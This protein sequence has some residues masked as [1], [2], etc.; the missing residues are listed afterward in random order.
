MVCG[1]NPSGPANDTLLV[2]K[3]ATERGRLLATVVNYACHPTTLAWENT[4]VSPDYIGALRESVEQHARAPCLFLQGAS[5][6][7]GPRHGYVGDTAVADANGRELAFAALAALEALPPPGTH[8][9]YSGPVESGATLGIWRHEPTSS[10]AAGHT[11]WQTVQVEVPLA[12]RKELSSKAATQAELSR[13]QDELQRRQAALDRDEAAKAHAHVER[14]TRQLWKLS[15]LPDGRYPLRATLARL[16]NAVWIFVSGELYQVLQTTLRAQFPENPLIV[17]TLSDGWQ[18]GYIPTADSY[19]H[20][21]YQEE[22]AV[23]AR[24]SL[25]Q[26]IGSLGAEIERLLDKS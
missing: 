8:F 3:I 9:A 7:L 13:W 4:L 21:I 15:E 1:F 19:G 22:I 17:A 23:V 6:D 12:Y 20:G 18:P 26:I 5:G 14:M 11:L 16:G 2:G 24:G 25:E 10:A